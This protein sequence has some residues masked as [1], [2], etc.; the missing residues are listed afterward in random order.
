MK[1]IVIIAA[2]GKGSRLAAGLP[3]CLVTVDDRTILEHQFK[4]FENF[5]EIR[6]VVGYKAE[7]VMEAAAALRRD[8]IFVRNDDYED[9]TTLQSMHMGAA[10]VAGKALFVDGDMVFGRMTAEATMAECAKGDEFIG[11]ASEI[12]DTPVYAGLENGKATWF[13]YERKSEYEWANMAFIDC[14]KLEY[15]KTHFFVQLQKFLPINA[16]HIDRL[17]IDTQNDLDIARKT[18]REHP[19]NFF[20]GRREK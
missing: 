10:G 9:T 14:A 8:V 11:V 2:A 4:A 6:M 1:K 15:R 17:E 13:S 20:F 5:D 7:R 12:S 19:E 3:K 18:I 16:F